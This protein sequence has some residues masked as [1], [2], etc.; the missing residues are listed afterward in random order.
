MVGGPL[1]AA[2][3][4]V[5]TGAAALE[6]TALDEAVLATTT[7]TAVVDGL[8]GTADDG[9]V[10]ELRPA[11]VFATVVGRTTDLLLLQAAT[12]TASVASEEPQ[13]CRL[14]LKSS[15]LIF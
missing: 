11:D 12:N 8:D 9:D 3:P 4:D 6:T 1:D 13:R 15:R 14:M 10:D 2:A 7:A 5:T